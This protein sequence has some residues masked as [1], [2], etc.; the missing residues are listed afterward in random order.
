M[1]TSQSIPGL[2]TEIRALID[3]AEKEARR[4]GSKSIDGRHV[5]FALI[6]FVRSKPGVILNSMGLSVERARLAALAP[7]PKPVVP[8]EEWA[9]VSIAPEVETLIKDARKTAVNFHHYLESIHFMSAILAPANR[10][11]S[12]RKVLRW[13]G[14]DIWKLG[15]LV[16][17]ELKRMRPA[18]G[19]TTVEDLKSG[20]IIP[21]PVS[22]ALIQRV[23]ASDWFAEDA[24]TVLAMANDERVLIGSDAI[25]IRS[26]LSAM[27]KLPGC[28]AG[29]LLRDAAMQFEDEFIVSH[30]QTPD[31]KA[32]SYSSL[33][34]RAMRESLI[35]SFKESRKWFDTHLNSYHLLLGMIRTIEDAVPDEVSVKYV[36]GL[37]TLKSLIETEQSRQ[38]Q[39]SKTSSGSA[40]SAEGPGGAAGGAGTSKSSKRKRT[41]KN[42]GNVI[43][44][45]GSVLK[46]LT[47]ASRAASSMEHEWINVA[48]L[49]LGLLQ[50]GRDANLSMIT[51]NPVLYETVGS[52]LEGLARSFESGSYSGDFAV[53]PRF[54]PKVIQV[55][56]D[57][58]ELSEQMHRDGASLEGLDVN[59]LALVLLRDEHRAVREIF[60][61]QEKLSALTRGLE[62]CIKWQ[63]QRNENQVLVEIDLSDL[64]DRFAGEESDKPPH[65]S[66]ISVLTKKVLE[67]AEE[68]AIKER[69]DSIHIEH[70]LLGIFNCR[71]LAIPEILEEAEYQAFELKCILKRRGSAR[72]TG[73]CRLAHT[74]DS[75]MKKAYG[76][77][78]SLGQTKTEPEHILLAILRE[79]D[80]LAYFALRVTGLEWEKMRLALESRIFHELKHETVERAES[81]SPEKAKPR[82]KRPKKSGA[83]ARKKGYKKRSYGRIDPE[84]GSSEIS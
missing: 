37:A 55:L 31:S 12:A 69:C 1:R 30:P 25:T 4:M 56:T 22:S 29:K 43:E 75:I 19:I 81:P 76:V 54:S 39:S 14:V 40:V 5:L 28:P 60:A 47:V 27:I 61:A 65:L 64:D 59:H 70:L 7:E 38:R 32:D 58:W 41:G 21:S 45:R 15:R 42:R 67:K 16:D 68:E 3:R 17:I 8:L 57:A 23:L 33:F 46:A 53:K 77:A 51:K 6:S 24:V 84:K 49:A 82:E 26:V 71:Y 9:I 11:N 66:R 74:A 18:P 36:K 10:L 72:S 20:A 78:Q 52:D 63:R 44:V 50:A 83:G 62:W 13:Y 79:A 73:R 34:D 48:H 35:A 2:T 80:G